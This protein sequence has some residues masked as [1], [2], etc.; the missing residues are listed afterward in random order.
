[1]PVI[2]LLGK[3]RQENC[4]KLGVSVQLGQ[5]S[6]T[7]SQKQK[8]ETKQN[9]KTQRKDLNSVENL[10]LKCFSLL[11]I[12]NRKIKV[13]GQPDQKVSKTSWPW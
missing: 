13:Q 6:E 2:Q 1:M 9:K 12:V 5:H 3:Q 4:L 11:G 7:P 10:S 8:A